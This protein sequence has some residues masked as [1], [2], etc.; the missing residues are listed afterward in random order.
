MKKKE[1]ILFVSI[2]NPEINK[3]H[4]NLKRQSRKSINRITSV[5]ILNGFNFLVLRFPSA[6]I[7]FYGLI[8]YYDRTEK[9]YSPSVFGYIVCREIKFC[10]RLVEFFQSFCYLSFIVQFFILLKLDK[11]FTEGFEQFKK[12]TS[13]RFYF[14]V[15]CKN[16]D[17]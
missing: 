6:A 12:K 13:K 10:P 3:R 14:D 7:S 1:K 8:Y 11:N 2:I 4:M 16:S 17:K 9:K 5:I 15:V